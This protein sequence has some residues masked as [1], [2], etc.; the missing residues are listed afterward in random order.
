MPIP[1]GFFSSLLKPVK[2]FIN[3][4]AQ[5]RPVT[6]ARHRQKRVLFGFPRLAVSGLALEPRTNQLR[7]TDARPKGLLT[8]P[9]V[10]VFR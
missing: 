3:S 10:E 2:L 8:Q 7:Q 5:Y 1:Q 9:F 6:N 4:L